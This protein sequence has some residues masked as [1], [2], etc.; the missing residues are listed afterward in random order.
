MAQKKRVFKGGFGRPAKNC[1]P[2]DGDT[3]D[4]VTSEGMDL[5]RKRMA[6][7]LAGRT[8]KSKDDSERVIR[9]G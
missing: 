7:V 9:F 8:F 1:L 2:L 6:E 3:D 5:V 4:T